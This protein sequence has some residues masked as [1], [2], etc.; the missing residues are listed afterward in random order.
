MYGTPKIIWI[1]NETVK[2]NLY[3]YQIEKERQR[4]TMLPGKGERWL[5]EGGAV[6][7]VSLSLSLWKMNRAFVKGKGNQQEFNISPIALELKGKVP[8]PM[9]RL[10]G[11]PI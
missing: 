11:G 5:P 2:P 8:S 7:G 10:V 9:E 3:I 6:V 4:E 1:W